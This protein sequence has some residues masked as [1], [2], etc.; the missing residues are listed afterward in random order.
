MTDAE[1]TV[2]ATR[3]ST[4]GQTVILFST[5]TV[6]PAAEPTSYYDDG[7]WHTR[8]AIKPAASPKAESPFSKGDDIAPQFVDTTKPAHANQNVA[9]N[10]TIKAVDDT[11]HA[12]R[13]VNTSASTPTVPANPNTAEGS[14]APL[15][16]IQPLLPEPTGTAA[17]A[18]PTGDAAAAP[19][20]LA[21]DDTP[22]V[23]QIARRASTYSVVSW[24][25]TTQG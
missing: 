12:R 15:M 8:Y 18:A 3:V 21:A 25:E 7:M 2:T 1:E 13:E 17:R 14:G 5:T 11:N 24:N 10:A 9:T 4:E 23:E 20:V 16:L 22:A 19:D 6:T